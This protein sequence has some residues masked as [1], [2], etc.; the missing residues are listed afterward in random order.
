MVGSGRGG[1]DCACVRGWWGCDSER[2]WEGEVSGLWLG[3]QP[4][5]AARDRSA[6]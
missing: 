3:D 4:A 6:G 1:I 5:N 2:G